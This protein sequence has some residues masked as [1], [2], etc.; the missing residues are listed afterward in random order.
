MTLAA[1]ENGMRSAAAAWASANGLAFAWDNSP[2]RNPHS[3]KT[4]VWSF[5]IFSQDRIT[6]SLVLVQGEAVGRI[7]VP[8]GTGALDG[9]ALADGLQATFAGMVYGGGDVGPEIAIRHLGRE[10][11]SYVF[12]VAIPWS[13]DEHRIPIGAIGEQGAPGAADAYQAFLA[14]WEQTVRAPLGLRSFFDNSPPSN[15]DAPPWALV[16]FRLLGPVAVDMATTRVPGRVIAALNFPLGTGL[17]DCEAAVATIQRAFD[18]TTFRGLVFGTPSVTRFGRT[19]IDT[20]Q[21][22]VRLPFHYDV[23]TP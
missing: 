19:P 3:A 21:T 16:S 13:I 22:N 11:Q 12:E 2:P 5:R 9:L 1:L 10:E 8:A 6:G 18:Q 17:T 20:W 7:Y 14:R 23:R 4:L 15:G